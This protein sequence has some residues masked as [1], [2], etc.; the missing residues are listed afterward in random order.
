M[1]CFPSPVSVHPAGV[2]APWRRRRSLGVSHPL[3][4][5]A[6]LCEDAAEHLQRR[7]ASSRRPNPPECDIFQQHLIGVTSAVA[8]C[9]YVECSV[10]VGATGA[11]QV[12]GSLS[13]D[14]PPLP[15]HRD[16]QQQGQVTVCTCLAGW[17]E[18]NVIHF[19]II[20]T[21]III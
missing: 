19:I 11:R 14:V 20:T 7:E 6:P 10:D 12:R 15:E 5:V 3:P 9:K 1:V 13:N 8:S 4:R 21:T 16:T 2:M 17:A 18:T